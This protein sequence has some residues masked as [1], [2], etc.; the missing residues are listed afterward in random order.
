MSWWPGCTGTLKCS[1]RSRRTRAPCSGPGSGIGSSPRSTVASSGPGVA[2]ADG[3]GRNVAGSVRRIHSTR[4][5]EGPQ[6]LVR[7]RSLDHD[8]WVVAALRREA[9]GEQLEPHGQR[10][11]REHRRKTRALAD[12]PDGDPRSLGGDRERLDQAAWIGREEGDHRVVRRERYGRAVEQVLGVVSLGGKARGLPQLERSL[13]RRDRGGSGTEH[14]QET[15]G[16][17]DVVDL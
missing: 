12:A 2:R 3:S 14:H 4:R 16:L 9:E 8:V 5:A 6:G 7:P 17:P 10:D 15:I 11:L 13:A 1:G